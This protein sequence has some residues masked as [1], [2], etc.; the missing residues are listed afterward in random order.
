[1]W[2]I[3]TKQR[4]TKIPKLYETEHVPLKE[5][6][7]YLHFFIGGCDWYVAEYDGKDLFWGFAI[8][9]NDLQ[10]AEWGYISFSELKSIKIQNW[11]E[12]DCET[13]EVW[14]VRKASAIEKI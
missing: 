14:Q 6:L 4:L 12:I 2:N 8:L 9:N 7:I 3:P 13:E 11:L 1:M 5:K 10:N